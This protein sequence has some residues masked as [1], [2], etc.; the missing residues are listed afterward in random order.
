MI[1]KLQNILKMVMLNWK[2]HWKYPEYH[3]RVRNDSIASFYYHKTHFTQ[4]CWKL[5]ALNSA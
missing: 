2:L 1:T 5:F 4:S 3:D